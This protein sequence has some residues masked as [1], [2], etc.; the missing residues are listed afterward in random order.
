MLQEFRGNQ[1]D[2][3]LGDM[4][5]YFK[6]SSEVDVIAVY[7]EGFVELDGLAFC[8]AV[9]DAVLA[10]VEKIGAVLREK[11]LDALVSIVNR[12]DINPAADD[13]AHARVAGILAADPGVEAVVLGLDPLSPA[14]HT[15]AETAIPAFGL[16]APESIARLLPEVARESDK[17]IIGVIDGGR[18]YDG[19][20]D[21]L[22]P[23]ACRSSRSPTEPWPPWPSTSR[24]DST[25]MCSGA[26]W[27]DKTGFDQVGETR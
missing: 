20:R 7:A 26:G 23:R 27:G 2:L 19:L 5:C 9:R 25:P 13:D 15:L 11:R 14:M 22:M 21:R 10:G 3:T 1:T 12:L 6:D 24:P 17:P 18:L 16:S 8:R 4:V